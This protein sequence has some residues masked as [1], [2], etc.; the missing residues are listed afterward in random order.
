MEILT[1]I[2]GETFRL[3][4]PFLVASTVVYAL[5]AVCTWLSERGR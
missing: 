1:G 2:M 4:A 5:G 3:L